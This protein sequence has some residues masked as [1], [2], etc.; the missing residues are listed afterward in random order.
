MAKSEEYIKLKS[1]EKLELSAW[2]HTNNGIKSIASQR[3][4]AHSSR[5]RYEEKGNT[6]NNRKKTRPLKNV[7]RKELNVMKE[8]EKE[9][10]LTAEVAALLN[11]KTNKV[12]NNNENMSIAWQV[13][14]IVARSKNDD[15]LGCCNEYSHL[16][17]QISR[18]TQLISSVGN[19]TTH[20]HPPG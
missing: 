9:Q 12:S 15:C 10:N 16:N 8:N 18:L 5:K 4:S 13:M 17:P 20:N 11:T 7:L 2:K 1:E 14:A 3:N 19:D 6:P